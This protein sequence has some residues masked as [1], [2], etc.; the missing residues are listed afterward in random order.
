MG[1]ITEHSSGIDPGNAGSTAA[2]RQARQRKQKV[3][4][5]LTWEQAEFLRRHLKQVPDDA[6][7]FANHLRD[8]EHWEIDPASFV[9]GIEAALDAQVPERRA[10]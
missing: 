2:R 3:A 9:D 10:S 5:T 6:F 1:R 8:E 4:V 7:E